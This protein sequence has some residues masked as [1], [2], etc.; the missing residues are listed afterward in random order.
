MAHTDGNRTK[1]A[2]LLGISVRTLYTKLR[3]YEEQAQP[4][5]QDSLASV[6]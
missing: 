2:R 1:A 4:A 3:E 6:S 5:L